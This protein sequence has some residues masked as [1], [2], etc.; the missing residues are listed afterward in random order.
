MLE[1]LLPNDA[2]HVL[3]L[4]TDEA[5]ARLVGDIVTES[6]EPGHTAATIFETQPSPARWTT[7]QWTLDIFFGFAPDETMVRA[8]VAPLVGD[9]IAAALTFS[10][11]AQTD[12]IAA[13]LTGLAPVRAGRF[14]VHGAHG[15]GTVRPYEIGLEIEAALAFGTGH[16][17]TT[18]GCLLALD[19]LLKRSAPQSILDIGTGTGVLAI[20]AARAL[21]QPVAAGDIDPIATQTARRNAIFNGAGAWVRPVTAAGLA[22]PALGRAGPFDVIFA[23]ILAKPLK[24]MAVSV[25]RAATGDATLILSGL[26]VPDAAGVLSTYAAQGFHLAR[27]RVIEGWVTLELRR[28]GGVPR[29]ETDDD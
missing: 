24:A 23:N 2:S 9:E 6:F 14:V 17:G 20:A 7:T 18:R 11:I 22:H 19:A 26:L 16:H 29:A 27:R 5:T 1:G 25:A 13:S 4:D 15:R 28:G 21:R 3:R 10:T 12:W 8:L